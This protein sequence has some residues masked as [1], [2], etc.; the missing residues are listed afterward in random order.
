MAGLLKKITEGLSD[1]DFKDQLRSWSG[2]GMYDG[3]LSDRMLPKGLDDLY[4]KGPLGNAG[5]IKAAAGS[6]GGSVMSGRA[7][8]QGG[9]KEQDMET[10]RTFD[11]FGSP[12]TAG[13]KQQTTAR[14]VAALYG[15]AMGGMALMGSGGGATSASAAPTSSSSGGWGATQ[16]SEVGGGGA[17][18]APSAG[19]SWQDYS[20]YQPPQQE[21]S[22]YEPA[23]PDYAQ[24]DEQRDYWQGR[25]AQLRMMADNAVRRYLS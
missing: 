25:A 10:A 4:R 5:G 17:S 19:S 23:Q 8:Y 6:K 7:I 1:F 11:V 20:Q 21:E 22:H 12:V 14:T 24:E 15:L 3:G 13:T 9:A 16:V 18:A 2:G